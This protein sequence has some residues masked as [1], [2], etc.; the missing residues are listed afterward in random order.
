VPDNPAKLE[1]VVR[2]PFAEVKIENIAESRIE[3]RSRSGESRKVANS[4]KD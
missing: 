1:S 2:N 4:L 3:S